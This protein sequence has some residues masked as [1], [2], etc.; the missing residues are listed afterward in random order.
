MYQHNQIHNQ[1]SQY[2]NNKQLS[3]KTKNTKRSN[4]EII[5]LNA[6]SVYAN[7]EKIEILCDEL[8]PNIVFCT[9]ARITEDLV[10][11]E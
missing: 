9:E 7:I 1:H 8:K 10:L 6:R 3:P 11:S 4:C 2:N 5:S